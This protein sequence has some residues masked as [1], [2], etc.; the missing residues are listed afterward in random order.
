MSRQILT[1]REKKQLLMFR[2][3]AALKQKGL[4]YWCGEVISNSFPANHPRRLTGDHLIP[5]HNGGKTVAGNIVA[6]CRECNNGRHDY[7]NRSKSS[8]ARVRFFNEE[9][10]YS[11][12]E[13]LKPE[14]G[15]NEDSQRKKC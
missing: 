2:N 5:L 6:A 14:E 10:I 3:R 8:D 13:K 11:P 9:K 4:C 15:K 1:S 7:M 12:F